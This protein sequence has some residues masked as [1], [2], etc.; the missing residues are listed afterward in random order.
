MGG[1]LQP[2]FFAVG[3]CA[4]AN[5]E[6]G[7]STLG[8]ALSWQQAIDRAVGALG[9]EM[10]DAERLAGG[11]LRVTIDRVPGRSYE[12]GPGDAVTVEDCERVTRQL[13]YALDVDGVDYARL[14]VSSPGL[15]RPLRK[16]ADWNRFTG[17]E[18]DLTL[19]TPFQGR[20]RWRGVLQA[21][22]AG[23]RLVLPPP[24]GKKA[25]PAAPSEALDFELNEVREAR[26]VPQ[27][28]FKGRRARQAA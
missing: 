15:D 14:E 25:A 8:S 18:V 28:D 11:L 17:S 22:D 13:Q 26:L 1:F 19:R 2:I 9:Y 20:K 16:P 23:W 10:V 21:R 7:L 27:L 4:A 12:A 3:E 5:V 24:E 6:Q